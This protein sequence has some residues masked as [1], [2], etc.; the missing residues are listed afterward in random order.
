MKLSVCEA[1]ISV[2]DIFVETKAITIYALFD[3][4]NYL[5]ICFNQAISTKVKTI[6]TINQT[7]TTFYKFYCQ[8]SLSGN[9]YRQRYAV[10]F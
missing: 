10:I 5:L 7:I 9:E 4:L 1:I 2:T 6:K 3:K 8:K